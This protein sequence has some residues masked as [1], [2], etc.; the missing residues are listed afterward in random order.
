MVAI[1]FRHTAGDHYPAVFSVR[2][3]DRHKFFHQPVT[4]QDYFQ[5]FLNGEFDIASSFML[6]F[7]HNHLNKPGLSVIMCKPFRFS[8][9]VFKTN[10]L[11]RLKKI[12]F[13]DLRGKKLMIHAR[14]V[15]KADDLVRDYL[16]THEPLIE[17]LDFPYYGHELVLK[18]ALENAVL[19]VIR[20]FAL[21]SPSVVYIPTDWDFLFERGLIYHKK[22]SPEVQNFIDMARQVIAKKNCDV[23][24]TKRQQLKSTC[25]LPEVR[26]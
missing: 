15:S 26:L 2:Y 8:I 22:C 6:N 12:T 14:G 9:C 16:E 24:T 4:F 1:E 3:I 25:T 21:D 5:A 13:A 10:P 23:I 18:A 20:E 11:A 17:V 19:L 7:V